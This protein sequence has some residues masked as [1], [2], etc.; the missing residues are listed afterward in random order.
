MSHYDVNTGYYLFKLIE[1]L[2][3]DPL[4]AFHIDELFQGSNA[5]LEG[6]YEE[7]KKSD[8][9]TRMWSEAVVTSSTDWYG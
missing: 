5:S 6:W 7:Y 9:M 2:K 8:E 4:S 3:A 1:A